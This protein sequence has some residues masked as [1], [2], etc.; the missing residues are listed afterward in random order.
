MKNKNLINQ[1]FIGIDPG[2]NGGLAC[3]DQAGSIRRK[4][5]MPV[6]KVGTK[7]KLDPRSIIAWLKQCMTEN[8]IRIVAIEEQR[9]MHKQ[10]VTSTFS[11][12]RG[13]G[14]LE[15]ITAALD[16]PYELVRAV[17]WQHEMFKGFPKGKT[18]EL[19]IR[20]AQQLYPKENY[21]KTSRCTNLHDG[22]SDAVCIAEFIRRK[23]K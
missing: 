10:G 4:I 23:I 16:L 13:Y 7:N 17:D 1:Y 20:V 22:L 14:I 5:I 6:I 8:E 12:G 11:I 9:P 19:S 2:I 3:L 18:K 15:G 21:K